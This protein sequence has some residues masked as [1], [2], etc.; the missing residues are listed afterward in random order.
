MLTVIIPTMW[1]ADGL[2]DRLHQLSTIAEVGEIILIDN[3]DTPPDLEIP[4]LVHIKEYKNTYVNPAWNKGVLLAKHDRL[5][6]MNDDINFE[7]DLF[8]KV[9]PHIGEDKG[10]IGLYNFDGIPYYDDEIEFKIV[11][12]RGWRGMG[13]ACLFFIHRRR[14]KPIPTD[15]K[16][17]FGDDY[18]FRFNG[19]TNYMMQNINV[20]GATSVTSRLTIFD[21]VKIR[22]SE[23]YSEI[24]KNA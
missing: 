7:N 13:Y 1:L 14:Y 16:V 10:M 20:W 23:I 9:E 2:L 11:E 18:L 19:G 15:M 3:S 22:D 6:I 8:S 21:S 24:L 12:S 4:K 17:W 5:C